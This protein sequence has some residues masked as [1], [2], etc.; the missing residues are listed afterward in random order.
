MPRLK[1]FVLILASIA[2]IAVIGA[3][4]YE[5]VAVV[6]QWSAAP[7]LSLSMFQGKYGL[8]PAPLWQSIPDRFVADGGRVEYNWRNERRKPIATVLVVY[9]MILVITMVIRA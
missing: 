3:A 1:T 5:H 4:I 2:F 7:P 8:N 9:V 6:P